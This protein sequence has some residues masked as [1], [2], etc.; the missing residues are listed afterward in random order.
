MPL[1]RSHFERN[2]QR[3]SRLFDQILLRLDPSHVDRE[4]AAGWP[5]EISP[6]HAI[7]A[8]RLV[9]PRMRHALAGSLEHLLSI[10]SGPLAGLSSRAPIHRERVRQAEPEIR[11]LIVALRA[12]GPIPVRGVA[13]AADLLTNGRGPIYN[14]VAPADLTTTITL[15][16][17]HLDPAVPLM[18]DVG[19]IGARN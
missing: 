15:A 6:R 16:L 5:P 14:P 12:A 2:H 9:A 11:R 10:A 1:S 19:S 18:P 13:I 7:R 8:R 17:E 3:M 4:L